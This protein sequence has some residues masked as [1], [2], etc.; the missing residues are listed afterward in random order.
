VSRPPGRSRAEHQAVG[1]GQCVRSPDGGSVFLKE[2]FNSN[3]TYGIDYIDFAD[4]TSWS[5]AKLLL[6]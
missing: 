2:E 6:L 5:R 1:R 3:T 4:G